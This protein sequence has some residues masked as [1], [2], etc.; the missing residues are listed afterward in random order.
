VSDSINPGIRDQVSRVL[1]AVENSIKWLETM[2]IEPEDPGS[3]GIIRSSTWHD[4]RRWPDMCLPATYNATMAR[5]LVNGVDSLSEE[6]C[7]GI[8]SFVTKFQEPDGSFWM[9][10]LTDETIYKHEDMGRTKEYIRL[11]ISNYARQVLRWVSPQNLKGPEFIDPLCEPGDIRSWFMNRNWDDPW[12]EGNTVINVAGLL[13]ERNATAA[14]EELVETLNTHQN[15]ETGFWG[16][17]PTTRRQLVHQ[18][19]G[20]MH[21]FHIYYFLGIP[22]PHAEKAIDIGLDLAEKELD[23]P[24][25][26]CLDVDVVDM[27]A[28][29]WPARYRRNDIHTVMRRKIDDVLSMQNPDGGFCDERAGIR[30]FDGWVGGYWEPQGKSNCFAT[31]FRLI[32]LAIAV[33]VIRPETIGHWQFRDTVGIGY[34]DPTRLSEA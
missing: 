1:S 21:V 16:R 27:L 20:A 17:T 7:S 29:L 26:A 32:A 33:S 13:V 28:S 24:V 15:S 10:G 22:V 14:L 5:I 34:F 31:W 9:P 3:A 12:M 4:V 25:S 8:A 2:E 30:R 6:E 18:F 23:G 19:A 11:H